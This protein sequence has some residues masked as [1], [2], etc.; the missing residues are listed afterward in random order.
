MPPPGPGRP[1]PPPRRPGPLH[2]LPCRPLMTRSG[3][4]PLLTVQGPGFPP[5]PFPHSPPQLSSIHFCTRPFPAPRGARAA[6]PGRRGCHGRPS[7]PR[8]P[9]AGQARAETAPR[10]A[11]A[12]AAPATGAVG[13]RPCKTPRPTHA[14]PTAAQHTPLRKGGPDQCTTFGGQRAAPCAA[15]PTALTSPPA[16][17]IPLFWPRA[18]PAP[19]PSPRCPGDTLPRRSTAGPQRSQCNCACSAASSMTWRDMVAAR[20]ARVQ[21]AGGR[22]GGGRGDSGPSGWA[23][24]DGHYWG[25]GVVVG[26]RSHAAAWRR[27]WHAAGAPRPRGRAAGARR[28]RLPGRARGAA[29]PWP[30]PSVAAPPHAAY[31][32][33]RAVTDATH[34]P[35]RAGGVG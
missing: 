13:T 12:P 4:R 11:R 1:P 34:R 2:P 16:A 22:A 17:F 35:R 28:A 3:A 27:V 5:A 15:Q 10:P 26:G 8:A 32:K 19:A 29:L 21:E 30:F 9:R 18:A 33:E 6:P 20:A 14:R 25:R 23:G 31:V 7:A 24:S